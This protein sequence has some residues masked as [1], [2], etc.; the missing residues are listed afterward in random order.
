MIP[1]ILILAL[2]F[3]LL[4]GIGASFEGGSGTSG[5]PY[6]IATCQQLQDIENDFFS[7]Y[8][9]VEDLNCNVT[10][11]WNSGKGFVPIGDN[12]NKFYGSLDGNGYMISNL[13]IDRSAEDQVAIFG[14]TA[15]DTVV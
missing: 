6:Q 13:Y 1:K 15:G 9:L 12:S 7:N 8:E 5:D 3:G 14:Y 11:S 2:T 10:E 4:S